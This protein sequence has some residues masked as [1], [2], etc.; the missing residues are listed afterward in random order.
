MT[1]SEDHSI[2]VDQLKELF[3]LSDTDGE[4]RLNRSQIFYLCQKI[5]L[6]TD[7]ENVVDTII[8]NNTTVNF[9]EF[10]D[11]FIEVL[12]TLE[13]PDNE[14]LPTPEASP[15][16]FHEG[17]RYGR[18]SRPDMTSD[19]DSSSSSPRSVRKNLTKQF[20]KNIG[21]NKEKKEE[22]AKNDAKNKEA[23]EKV[24]PKVEE[25]PAEV[26]AIKVDEDT[27]DGAA[28]TEHNGAATTEQ[29]YEAEGQMNRSMANMEARQGS[30]SPRTI[31]NEE[32]AHLRSIWADLG[33][34]SGG[35]LTMSELNQVCMH[36][37]M[38][39]MDD[40]DLMQLFEN[41]DVD[42]D[43]TV[44][45]DEFMLGLFQ[46]GPASTASPAV[47][48]ESR[49]LSSKKI[50]RP[51]SSVTPST[52]GSGLFSVLDPHNTGFAR[53][54]EIVELWEQLGVHDGNKILKNMQFDLHSKVNLQELSAALEHELVNG[55]Q[56]SAAYN[57]AVLTYNQEVQYLKSNLEQTTGHNN[58]LQSDLQEANARINFLVHEGD[59][60]YHNL[61]STKNKEIQTVERKYQ[62]Q[63]KTLQ[64][65]L[66]Q[67]RDIGSAKLETQRKT[68]EKV[69]ID[70]KEEETRLKEKVQDLG[71]EIRRLELDLQES[72][73]QL[74]E[75]E[76]VVARQQRELETVSELQRKLALD[77]KIRNEFKIADLESS[78]DVHNK[79][80]QRHSQMKLHKAHED[81]K[82]LRD[83]NDELR[84]EVESLRHDLANQNRRTA[85]KRGSSIPIRNGS[86]LSDYTKPHL[87]KLGPPSTEDSDEEQSPPSDRHKLP[88][89]RGEGD[90]YT[91][92]VST[93]LKAEI[94][95]MKSSYEKQI[96]NLRQKNDIERQDVEE[97]FKAE[98]KEIEEKNQ[99]EKED[100][101][102]QY[103][104]DREQLNSDFDTE[105]ADLELR[106]KEEAL[107]VHKKEIDKLIDEHKREKKQIEQKNAE[108][109]ANLIQRLRKENDE[110]IEA[111]I[112]EIKEAIEKQKLNES[113]ARSGQIAD[114]ELQMKL[115]QEEMS[116][117]FS[118]EMASMRDRFNEEKARMQELH[119]IEVNEYE[120]MFVKGEESLRGKLRDDFHSL[121]DKSIVYKIAAER[122]RL[123]EEFQKEKAELQEQNQL[124]QAQ[125][126]QAYTQE[127]LELEAQL[128]AKN[129]DMDSKLRQV[130][131]ETREH[132]E[133]E[134]SQRIRDMKQAFRGE[135]QELEDSKRA[136]EAENEDLRLTNMQNSDYIRRVDELKKRNDELNTKLAKLEA[137]KRLADDMVQELHV[138][139]EEAIVA[140]EAHKAMAYEDMTKKELEVGE[141]LNREKEYNDSLKAS[142]E[143]IMKEKKDVERE[144]NEMKKKVDDHRYSVDKKNVEVSSLQDTNRKLATAIEDMTKQMD[145]KIHEC[146]DALVYKSRLQEKYDKLVKDHEDLKWQYDLRLKDIAEKCHEVDDMKHENDIL[147]QKKED[148]ETA[149]MEIEDSLNT[150]DTELSHLQKNNVQLTEVVD[151]SNF[152]LGEKMDQLQEKIKELQT[153]KDMNEKGNRLKSELNHRNKLLEQERDE[154]E[155]DITALKRSN[156][157]HRGSKGNDCYTANSAADD[158]E[159]KA[160]NLVRNITEL[161]NEKK[162]L[163]DENKALN[164]DKKMLQD[165][166]KDSRSD[167]RH[168]S[169]QLDEIKL[170]NDSLE[171]ENLQ[172]RKDMDSTAKQANTMKAANEKLTEAVDRSVRNLE[173]EMIESKAVAEIAEKYRAELAA[174]KRQK[175][176]SEHNLKSTQ[177]KTLKDIERLEQRNQ[178]LEEMNKDM[179]REKNELTQTIHE[180][181]SR[182]RQLNSVQR[183][184]NDVKTKL[185]STQQENG[186]L[187]QQLQNANDKLAELATNLS[188]VD[189]EHTR[190]IQDMTD[191]Q[192]HMV[193]MNK[194]NDVNMKMVEQER[195]IMELENMIQ[196]RCAEYNKLL[197]EAQQD[198]NQSLKQ[199]DE[200]KQDANK[201][202]NIANSLLKETVNKLKKQL[203][204]CTKSDLLVQ[205]LY[206]EN[207]SLMKALQVT[208]E[209]QKIAESRCYNLEDKCKALH[210]VVAKITHAALEP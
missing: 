14:N 81:N 13:S 24:E 5:Q 72:Q 43:G 209:R 180:L 205:E 79:E 128:K 16:F 173:K 172:L 88:G 56:K 30:P 154:L 151:H 109:R 136:M 41:L 168:F 2:L 116:L 84:A 113:D 99:R 95:A 143:R 201:K 20:K 192:K 15:K 137:E 19:V 45:F 139:K 75:S 26:P 122:D 164:D 64:S 159:T 69:I 188:L 187:K 202:L 203:E 58:K 40:K 105:R 23:K 74:I 194:F 107:A 108:D 71:Q 166:M 174:I 141:R 197:I 6:H 124:E 190:H 158:L 117:Q 142:N 179:K 55:D 204:R 25:A 120:N 133:D 70:L 18:R 101:I 61:E 94:D 102:R 29:T 123:L 31:G 167:A 183:D 67:E 186:H 208:E 200:D 149:M 90:G 195:R 8:A 7:I 46:H 144:L 184:C 53:P 199:T 140:S 97:A 114:L 63:L 131:A 10:R 148:L 66:E 73:E 48:S 126:C 150:R 129:Q 135:M 3:Q 198:F 185:D 11:G 28:T 36:I 162:A 165:N 193:D 57:A 160:Q 112:A 147:L 138:A 51:S 152:T 12:E 191:K 85:G 42:G 100:L 80:Q 32:E 21:E 155:K 78:H 77:N 111:R 119:R 35:Y 39:E 145:S 59:E 178:K 1:M 161:Q 156:Y 54:D 9:E 169:V 47:Q 103:K 49:P 83:K 175:D 65:D 68:M 196:I 106:I 121:V 4:G 52:G 125:L 96:K 91:E 157:L 50:H 104:Y 82:F 181:E 210:K 127:K 33:V 146:Q 163:S 93:K 92:E 87:K 76:K 60:R 176:D 170:K 38:E 89:R 130:E 207:A 118:K 132:L 98:I 177:E 62:E 37:G 110:E 27:T 34:G 134:F 44:S 206:K 86:K 189:S 17:K 22:S 171:K 115:Q 182:M 153:T